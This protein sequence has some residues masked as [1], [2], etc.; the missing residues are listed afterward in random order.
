MR[1]VLT[2]D[3]R[4]TRHAPESFVLAANPKRSL[5]VHC[6][7]VRNHIDDRIRSARLAGA[8][9]IRSTDPNRTV[10]RFGEEIRKITWP[11][12]DFRVRELRLSQTALEVAIDGIQPLSAI[13][14][15]P[16]ASVDL[17]RSC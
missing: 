9:R 13:F 10:G 3:R 8:D 17:L 16:Y 15:E 11:H 7:E 4:R 5:P 1:E 12:G 2:D 6:D 14:L